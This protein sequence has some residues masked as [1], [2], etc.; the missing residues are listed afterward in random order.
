EVGKLS[1]DPA[2]ARPAKSHNKNAKPKAVATSVSTP[3]DSTPA[4]QPSGPVMPVKVS[5]GATV[6]VKANPLSA[7]PNPLSGKANPVNSGSS[8]TESLNKRANPL[9]SSSESINRRANPLNSSSES[10]NR[11]ANPLNRSSSSVNDDTATKEKEKDDD[12][13]PVTPAANI[14]MKFGAQAS[15]YRFMNGKVKLQYD[16]LNGYWDNLTNEI[17]GIEANNKFM[18]IPIN[19]PGGRIAILKT[20]D[21]G[22]IPA[23]MNCVICGST[24]TYFKFNPF[25]QNMLITG[26]EN[27]NVQIWT[28]PDDDLTENLTEPDH[29]FSCKILNSIVL[30]K[31]INY[32][33]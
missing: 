25:N 30:L 11:R 18:A 23:T 20:R 7:K 22:R 2:K 31:N 10:I 5:L 16:N 15:S 32:F 24:M 13:P 17:D 4:P 12:E 21:S 29:T 1:L 14:A 33:L 3:V 19:G 27:G 6:P 8:S 9:N 26:N 28:I